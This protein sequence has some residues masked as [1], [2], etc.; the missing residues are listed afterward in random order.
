MNLSSRSESK[1][2]KYLRLATELKRFYGLK[3]VKLY[4]IIIGACGTVLK[5]AKNTFKELFDKQGSNAMKRA[6]TNNNGKI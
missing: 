3:S 6:K 1:A 4:D 5:G 2:G